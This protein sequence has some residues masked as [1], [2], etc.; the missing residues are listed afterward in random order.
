MATGQR[1][2]YINAGEELQKV[3][4]FAD[5]SKLIGESTVEIDTCGTEQTKQKCPNLPI[6][7][8]G[9][10]LFQNWSAEHS[11]SVILCRKGILKDLLY[12]GKTFALI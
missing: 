12:N 3:Q 6:T 5:K 8:D 10:L 7:D 9:F 2:L 1:V 11:R 4:C